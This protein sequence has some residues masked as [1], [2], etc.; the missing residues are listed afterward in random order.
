MEMMKINGTWWIKGHGMFS[1]HE[2]GGLL[3]THAPPFKKL[4]TIIGQS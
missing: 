3:R 2:E 1:A 4:P